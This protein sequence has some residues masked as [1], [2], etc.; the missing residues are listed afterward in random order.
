MLVLMLAG[1]F[2]GLVVVSCIVLTRQSHALYDNKSTVVLSGLITRVKHFSRSV[3]AER[4]A[5]VGY[6][7]SGGVNSTGLQQTREAVNREFVAFEDYA[8]QQ[9]E[10]PL[11]LVVRVAIC[12]DIMTQREH[13]EDSVNDLKADPLKIDELYTTGIAKC[14]NLVLESFQYTGSVRSSIGV[15]TAALLLDTEELLEIATLRISHKLRT[16]VLD[17][18]SLQLLIGTRER[19]RINLHRLSLQATEQTAAALSNPDLSRGR[20]ACELQLLDIW[21]S[22]QVDPSMATKLVSEEHAYIEVFNDIFTKFLETEEELASTDYR[23]LVFQNVL[24]ISMSV[25]AILIGVG[26]GIYAASAVAVPFGQLSK[27][28]KELVAERQRLGAQTRAVNCFVPYETLSLLGHANITTLE[29]GSN[30]LKRLTVL[31]VNVNNFDGLQ[32]QLS[33]EETVV[34]LNTWLSVVVPAV[35]DHG[36]CIDKLMGDMVLMFFEKPKKAMTAAMAMFE[37]MNR[38]NQVNMDTGA[39][40]LG[41]TIGMNT[42]EVCLGTIGT[43]TRMETTTIGDAVN[44]T[45]RVNSLAKMFHSYFLITHSTYMQVKK[46]GYQCRCLG[47]SSVKGRPNKVKVYEVLDVESPVQKVRRLGTAAKF[48]AAQEAFDNGDYQ[49]ARPLIIAVLQ[50]NPQDGAAQYLLRWIEDGPVQ[51]VK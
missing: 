29:V 24:F 44:V 40:S 26:M 47:L 32:E 48:Q 9:V 14:Y 43:S 33:L 22:N 46:E 23:A 51:F 30:L 4:A 18:P 1:P 7:M 8:S 21:I 42:G 35:K 5:T 39:E 45:S 50:D 36:G 3:Q 49:K 41:L 17:Q 13:L 16:G 19:V 38:H 20:E 12:Q 15:V 6:L 37:S 2:A 11:P 25:G 31:F 10:L 34:Y 27:T 28:K